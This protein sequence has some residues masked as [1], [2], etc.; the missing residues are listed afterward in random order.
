MAMTSTWPPRLRTDPR[1]PSS[2]AMTQTNGRNPTP[3]TRP[4]I[5]QVCPISLLTALLRADG[6]GFT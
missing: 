6:M 5:S 2:L 3:W 1:T 4:P